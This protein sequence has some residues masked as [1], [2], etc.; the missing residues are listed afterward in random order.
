MVYSEIIV[1][2]DK[3]SLQCFVTIQKQIVNVVDQ[4]VAQISENLKFN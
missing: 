4:R 1:I 3:M 2:L